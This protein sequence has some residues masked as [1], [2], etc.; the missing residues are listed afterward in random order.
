[1]KKRYVVL[2][3][4][5]FV[6]LG[7]FGLIRESSFTHVDAFAVRHQALLEE[8]LTLARAEVS[9]PHDGHKPDAVYTRYGDNLLVGRSYVSPSGISTYPVSSELRSVWKDIQQKG[10][11]TAVDC[12]FEPDG[13]MEA[14]LSI[15]GG[16]RSYEEGNYKL[17]YCLIW[18]DTGYSS[19]S[20]ASL[21]PMTEVEGMSPSSEGCW[22]WTS[23]KHYD[24]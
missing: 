13:A 6:C 7:L 18:R 15:E 20:P 5:A 3:V 12:S 4:A 17:C 11:F 2:A 21:D 22:Y 10:H 14:H 9:V 19:A 24:G 16:W 1:M 23:H 8:F